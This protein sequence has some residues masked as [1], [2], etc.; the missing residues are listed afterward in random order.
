MKNYRFIDK[1]IIERPINIKANDIEEATDIFLEI[2]SQTDLLTRNSNGNK[3]EFHEVLVES[4]DEGICQYLSDYY[5]LDKYKYD[6]I[7]DDI[8]NWE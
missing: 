3:V 7:Y 6:D 1:R 5:D 2:I 8:D 4:N